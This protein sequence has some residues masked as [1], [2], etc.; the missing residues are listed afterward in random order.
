MFVI[1]SYTP[2][3]MKNALRIERDTIKGDTIKKIKML[4]GSTDTFAQRKGRTH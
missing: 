3:E 2:E 4:Y 1:L